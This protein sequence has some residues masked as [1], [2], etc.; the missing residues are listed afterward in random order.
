[1]YLAFILKVDVTDVIHSGK[2]RRRS[3]RTAR[4]AAPDGLT[5]YRLSVRV[6]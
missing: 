2:L 4:S 5:H 3:L 1:M 6:S